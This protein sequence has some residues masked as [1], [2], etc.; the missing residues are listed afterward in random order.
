MPLEP[1]AV[2]GSVLSTVAVGAA[3]VTL[4]AQAG[5]VAV[6]SLVLARGVAEPMTLEPLVDAEASGE[7][8]PQAVEARLEP[9]AAQV[10]MGHPVILAVGMVRAAVLVRLVVPQEAMVVSVGRLGAEVGA[11]VPLQVDKVA[12]AEMGVLESL[13]FGHIK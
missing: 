6:L 1:L 8:I 3:T 10:A 7:R 11:E 12:M 9:A 4:A 13:G 5:T 2:Q